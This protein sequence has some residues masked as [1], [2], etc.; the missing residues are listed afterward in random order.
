MSYTPEKSISG[1][2]LGNWK[3]GDL[4][5]LPR[6]PLKINGLQTRYAW[7]RA[8]GAGTTEAALLAGYAE[9]TARH[10]MDLTEARNPDILEAIELFKAHLCTTGAMSAQKFIQNLNEIVNNNIFD[11][12]TEDGDV[13]P[14]KDIARHLGQ[15]LKAYRVTYKGVDPP[16]RQVT[17]E[18]ESRERAREL[19]AKILGLIQEK[20]QGEGM[21]LQIHIGDY[22]LMPSSAPGDGTEIAKDRSLEMIGHIALQA[23]PSREDTGGG[24]G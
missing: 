21:N 4:L 11:Y 20:P 24:N 3:P 13:R 1:T 8:C 19:L 12:L 14:P 18:L 23:P 15:Y 6:I 2:A 17:I 5:V 7:F 9:A 10:N 16:I 22:T